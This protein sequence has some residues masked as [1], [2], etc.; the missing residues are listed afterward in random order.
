VK[1][2]RTTWVLIVVAAS[3][4]A[5]AAYAISH[6]A[7]PGNRYLLGIASGGVAYYNDFSISSGCGVRQYSVYG[8]NNSEKHR[9]YTEAYVA[10][11]KLRVR[12]P[13]CLIGT[14][15]L[16]MLIAAVSLSSTALILLFFKPRGDARNVPSSAVAK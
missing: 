6:S 9:A 7:A 2:L 8:W 10:S 5:A 13:F 14:P 3:L 1:H 4:A 16:I 12:T 15:S 11:H